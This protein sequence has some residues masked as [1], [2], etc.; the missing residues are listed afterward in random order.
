MEPVEDCKE[1]I[2]ALAE[3]RLEMDPVL[4]DSTWT[5]PTDAVTL[6]RTVSEASRDAT[7]AAK[8]ERRVAV[9]LDTTALDTL[10]PFAEI[11]E[12]DKLEIFA[13]VEISREESKSCT[14][15]VDE[16]SAPT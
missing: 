14:L 10:R 13:V 4:D 12:E 8:D 15:A 11:C 2:T 5:V 9:R 3:V 7:D 1:A 6:P 16:L